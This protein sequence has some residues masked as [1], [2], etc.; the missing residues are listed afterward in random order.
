[1]SR[2]IY[3]D[4]NATTRT[5]PAVVAEML[6]F[7]S[8]Q[9]GN[10]S[11]THAFGSEV[12][13]ALKQARAR[14]QALIGAAFD[15]EIVFTSGGSESDNA[16]ILAALAAD[17]QRDEI[18]T[19]AVEHPAILSLVGHL[20]KTRGVKVHY[21]G[22]DAFGRLDLETFERALGPRTAIASVMWAN[23]ETGVVFPVRALAELA[24][25]AGALFHTDAVQA[26]GKID[27]DLKATEIDMASLSGHKIHGPKGVG[28]LYVRKG[29]KFAPLVR[30]GRQERGRRAGTENTPAIV[31]LG[32]AAELAALRMGE[33]R[34][35]IESLRAR[36]EARLLGAIDD[37]FILGDQ[38]N[39]LPNTSDIAFEFLDSEAIL[40]NLQKDGVAASSGSACASGSMEPSHVLRAMNVRPTALH[41]AIR[42]SLS[43][44]TTSREIDQVIDVL[45]G[46]VARL[47]AMSPLWRERTA[48]QG[49][50]AAA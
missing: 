1:M 29:V 11:S 2:P 39:R 26:V 30:G 15:H 43:R 20:E 41:G 14:L 50:G 25:R 40:H 34:E 21:I 22:V 5:D 44:E 10:A 24:H 13:G 27:I 37:C 38:K 3:L 19:T 16:A 35:V 46:I 36:L 49:S 23:N 4:N 12:A 42:F 18:V 48:A 45:P 6:P 28:A 17:P 33:D 31:G 7:F 9:F 32:K 8:E 47:R